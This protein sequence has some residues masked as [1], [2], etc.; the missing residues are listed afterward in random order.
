M[1]PACYSFR[2]MTRRLDATDEFHQLIEDVGTLRRDVVGLAEDSLESA[3]S[4]SS[5]PSRQRREPAPLPTALRG[6]NPGRCKHA[7]HCGPV[8]S[9][10]CLES[11][12]LS[13]VD[14]V[15]MVLHRALNLPWAPK[16]PRKTA[17]DLDRGQRLLA[18]HTAALLG[19]IPPSRGAAIMVTL[20]SEAA[21]DYTL[22]HKFDR[23]WHGLRADQLRAR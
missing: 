21:D 4:G 18:A 15:L 3:R 17:V 7:G 14:A 23:A 19:G 22:V 1:T 12:V 10:A 13:A 2:C 11:H 8:I 20:P 9:G 16:N 5:K 6:T